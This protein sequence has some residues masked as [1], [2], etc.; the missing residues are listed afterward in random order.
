MPLPELNTSGVDIGNTLKT[1]MALKAEKQKQARENTLLGWQTQNYLSEIA[2]RPTAEMVQ[3]KANSENAL[4]VVQQKREQAQLDA[5]RR[6]EV[7]SSLR[8]IEAG[9]NDP[10]WQEAAY[11]D[12]AK[13]TTEKGNAPPTGFLPSAYFYNKEGKW[14]PKRFSDWS[15]E[16][17]YAMTGT[18]N[19]KEGDKFPVT[20][21][22]PSFDPKKP[23]SETNPKVVKRHIVIENGKPT[24]LDVPDE[25]MVSEF[26]KAPKA[27]NMPSWYDSMLKESLGSGTDDPTKVKAFDDWLTTTE[28][29]AAA[30]RY[31]KQYAG[32]TAAP[33]NTFIGVDPTSGKPIGWNTRG[34]NVTESPTPAPKGGIAPKTMS[35]DYK[36]DLTAVKQAQDLIDGLKKNWDSLKITTR[37]SAVGKY[38]TGK[39]GY[40]AQAKV[41]ADT[42]DA[43]LGNL[44]RSVAAERGVLTQQDIERVAKALPA[45]GPNPLTVDNKKEADLKW[46]EINSIITNAK[47][48]MGERSRMTYSNTTGEGAEA[49]GE[50]YRV[51]GS[52]QGKKITRTGWDGSQRVLLLDDGT[53]VRP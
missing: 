42:R 40:D 8:F 25:P 3:Q 34:G 46:K 49:E 37:A 23:E 35:E 48:R 43:F 7:S 9:K 50:T 12:F 27:I 20:M 45:L 21:V 28:G 16:T 14:D 44:S 47:K 4:R 10:A 13:A 15:K 38:A 19:P 5:E 31:R 36:K 18:V 26:T 22:N 11:N 17:H 29:K 53:E 30:S 2:A 39:T 41:Y 1:I 51:G 52:Y 24:R 6:K 32:E 33:Y